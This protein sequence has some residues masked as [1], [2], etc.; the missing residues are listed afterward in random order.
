ML[1][2]K[3]TASSGRI[4]RSI[5]IIPAHQHDWIL[6]PTGVIIS[7]AGIELTVMWVNP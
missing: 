7:H 3:K 4:I 1:I 5:S 6:K 2:K